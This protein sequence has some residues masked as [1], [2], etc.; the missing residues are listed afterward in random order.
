MG[1][2]EYKR[3]QEKLTEK[4]IEEEVEIVSRK[5]L[6]DTLLDKKQLN[7]DDVKITRNKQCCTLDIKLA[8][9]LY[10]CFGTNPERNFCNNDYLTH[11]T[12]GDRDITK[13]HFQK[14]FSSTIA[15]EANIQ[16]NGLTSKKDPIWTFTSCNEIIYHQSCDEMA[17]KVSIERK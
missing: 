17:Q 1:F 4:K 8:L 12:T 13:N 2:Q 15:L 16:V 6:I 5:E 9:A 7:E 14:P 10:H 3:K 11:E